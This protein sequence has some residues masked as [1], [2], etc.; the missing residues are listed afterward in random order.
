MIELSRMQEGEA[1]LYILLKGR[2]IMFALL[3]VL[4]GSRALLY[5]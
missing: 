3:V 5:T 4:C 2:L 1:S